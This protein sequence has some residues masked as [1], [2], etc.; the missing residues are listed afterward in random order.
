M[1]DISDLDNSFDVEKLWNKSI[2]LFWKTIWKSS[3]VKLTW[4]LFLLVNKNEHI[5]R[6]SCIST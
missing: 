3:L 5:L 4:I 1:F 6:L 2:Q